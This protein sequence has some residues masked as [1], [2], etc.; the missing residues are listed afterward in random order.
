MYDYFSLTKDVKRWQ[1][2]GAKVD[3]IGKSAAGRELFYVKAGTGDIAVLI[4]G[5]IHARE[6][7]TAKLVANLADLYLHKNLKGSIYFIPMMNPDGVEICK[8]GFDCLLDKN[9]AAKLKK[10]N[11]LPALYKAN[12]N[13]VDLNVN[14]DA[15]FAK[16]KKNIFTPWSENYVGAYPLCEPESKALAEFTKAAS[17]SGTISYHAKG[18]EIY[19]YF[20]QKKFFTRDEKIAKKIS[21]ITQYPLKKTPGSAGGYKDYCIMHYK[22]PSLTIEVGNDNCGYNELYD[23]FASIKEK[24]FT[25][26]KIFLNSVIE[27]I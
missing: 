2:E 12:A 9:L 13:G 15:R 18:E 17:L 7:I 5:A 8:K 3:S 19:W 21:E 24:N 11:Q 10:E 16:G 25:V 6:H 1:K 14:F 4:Q 26:P 20:G 22:I 23:E 27:F